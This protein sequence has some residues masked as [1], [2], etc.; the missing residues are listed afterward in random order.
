[1]N[2]K[3]RHVWYVFLGFWLYVFV[4]IA[5]RHEYLKRAAVRLPS[6]DYYQN[7]MPYQTTFFYDKDGAVIGCTAEE[8]RE[9]V[10]KEIIDSLLVT[11]L[12]TETEDQRYFEWYRAWLPIDPIGIL[13]ALWENIR[14]GKIVEGGSTI[15]QQA[16][17]QLLDPSEQK[18]R[19]VTR[20]IK[21]LAIA[22]QL[23]RAFDKKTIRW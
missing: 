5:H 1:M 21:E 20:K 19:T 17:K 22:F 3:I 14:A 18:K 6:L 23:Q 7:Y 4:S 2:F 13:R 10:P 11:T 8:W 9:V 15:E 16:A 12:I